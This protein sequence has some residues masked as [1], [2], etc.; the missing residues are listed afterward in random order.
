[1]CLTFLENVIVLKLSHWIKTS[2]ETG[3]VFQRL[4]EEIIFKLKNDIKNTIWLTIQT[5]LYN[6]LWTCYAYRLDVADWT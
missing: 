1:M 2:V 4:V 5:L 3:R 6:L